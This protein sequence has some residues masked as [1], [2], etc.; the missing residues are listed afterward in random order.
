VSNSTLKLQLLI[1]FAFAGAED[2]KIPNIEA[3]V[4]YW[5]AAKLLRLWRW[6]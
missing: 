5:K 3:L 1:S 6:K 4:R 2:N